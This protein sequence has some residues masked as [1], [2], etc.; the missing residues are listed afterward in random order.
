MLT[1][2]IVS[3]VVSKFDFQV[4]KFPLSGP[5]NMPTS[6]YGLFRSGG[7]GKTECIS[8][9]SV[10][11]QYVPHTTDDVLA[12]V[13][14]GANAFDGEINV[15]CY[16][17]GGHYVNLMPTKEERLEVYNNDGVIPRIIVN[18]SYNGRAFNATMGFW[19]DLCSNMS[20]LRS[21]ES[22]T[23]SIRHSSGLRLEMDELI[24]QFGV[25]KE[26]WGDLSAAILNMQS[27]Q[28]AIADILKEIYGEPEKTEG[29]GATI[30][31]NRT[32]L[33]VRRILSEQARTGRSAPTNG[34]VS[35]WEMFNGIQGYVQHDSSRKGDVTDFSRI[36]DA[37]NDRAVR[38]AETLLVA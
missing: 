34:M 17:R 29:R 23:V 3:T 4:E 33:I 31:K 28:V 10:T 6:L 8:K 21:V 7:T 18:A 13:E 25:L 30:H 36:I 11:K 9:Q 22:T 5:D 1:Q 38:K 37:S 27:R 32:E 24:E 19:R 16:F 15:D 35:A 14:A 2:D 12:L 26:S 20:M